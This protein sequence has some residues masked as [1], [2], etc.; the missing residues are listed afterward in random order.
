[1]PILG[2]A[3]LLHMAPPARLAPTG[4][5]NI[6]NLDHVHKKIGVKGF[7]KLKGL[8]A[9]SKLVTGQVLA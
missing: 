2:L 6:V 5:K 8:K 4:V 3:E 7:F 9:C 1:V